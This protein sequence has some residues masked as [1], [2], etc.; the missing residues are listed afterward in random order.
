[1]SYSTCSY[2]LAHQFTTA[3]HHFW[4]FTFLARFHVFFVYLQ[5]NMNVYLL[6]IISIPVKIWNTTQK[7]KVYYC[8]TITPDKAH[9]SPKSTGPSCSKLTMLLVNESLKFTSSDMQIC[10]NFLL[11]K[12][13][14]KLLTFFQ[15]KNIRI[16]YIESAKT[17]NEMTLYELVKLTTL[18]T[19][20][21]WFFLFLHENMLWVLMRSTLLRCFLW[22]LTTYV[23]VEK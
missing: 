2:I 6:L 1:M 17:V 9:F 5:V 19:T 11:K 20:G 23:F 22:V 18:W 8:I 14:V 7:Y 3:V 12:M 16:L 15:Q 10:W 13:W 4:D 21:P